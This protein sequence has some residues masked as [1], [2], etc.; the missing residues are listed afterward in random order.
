MSSWQGG[1]KEEQVNCQPEEMAERFVW[2]CD[3]SERERERESERGAKFISQP[4]VR[5]GSVS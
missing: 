5:P 2:V 1:A 3:E 4:P